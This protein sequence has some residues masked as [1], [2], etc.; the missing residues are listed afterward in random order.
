MAASANRIVPAFT[1][2]VSP[3]SAADCETVCPPALIVIVPPAPALPTVSAPPIMTLPLLVKIRSAVVVAAKLITSLMVSVES[4][5]RVRLAEVPTGLIGALTV[6]VPS[7]VTVTE[8]AVVVVTVTAVPSS[9]ASMISWLS[10][11]APVAVGLKE[12]EGVTLTDV[13]VEIVILSGSIS[14]NPPFPFGADAFTLPKAWRL[15]LEEVS[16]KPPSPPN[17]PPRAEIS[18]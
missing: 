5:S 13:L 17:A 6:K 14:H 4:A 3:V 18:P 7:S 9:K 8:A 10:T 15:F 16:T 2:S 11:L 1:V 12:G